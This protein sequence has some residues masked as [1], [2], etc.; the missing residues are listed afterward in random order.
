MEPFSWSSAV[1]NSDFEMRNDG[2][3]GNSS[4]RCGLVLDSVRGELVEAPAK[5]ERKGVSAERTIEALKN[6]SEAE[7][8][9][10]ARINSHFDTLRSLLPGAMKM[11]KAS[12]LAEVISHL[13][14]LKRK[15]AEMSEDCAIPK[16][17]D[18]VKV[19]PEDEL[20]G[21]PYSIRVS[22]S[23]DYKPGLLSDLRQALDALQVI[24]MSAEIATL[25]CRMKNVFVITTCNENKIED[26]DVRRFQARSICQALRSVLDKFSASDQFIGNTLSNKKRRV[27]VFNP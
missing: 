19:E 10:R 17:F 9:R 23:C 7:K 11:D 13:K 2:Y 3:L 14:D 15:T 20:E 26:D 5:L 12:L 22:L 8:R 25:G 21:R 4:I 18:E 27:S 6:H 24:V 16:D 1:S